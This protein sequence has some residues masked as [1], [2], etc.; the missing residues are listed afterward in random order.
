VQ[1]A[2]QHPARKEMVHKQANNLCYL[3]AGGA[4]VCVKFLERGLI[5]LNLHRQILKSLILIE[6]SMKDVASH[7]TYEESA[8]DIK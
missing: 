5:I 4:E 1:D 8:N 2:Q 6:R 3:C 7:F